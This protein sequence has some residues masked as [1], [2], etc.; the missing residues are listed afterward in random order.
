[1]DTLFSLPTFRTEGW[2]QSLLIFVDPTP[3][4]GVPVPSVST[5]TPR[6]VMFRSSSRVGPTETGGGVTGPRPVLF[7]PQVVIP[8]WGVY[9]PRCGVD[10]SR[11]CPG[12]GRSSTL[13]SSPVPVT[14]VPSF[15]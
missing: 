5:P 12:E 7:C 1:M 8:L 15:G 4:P 14:P 13:V 10:P 6:C 2:T 3:T 9:T 11:R